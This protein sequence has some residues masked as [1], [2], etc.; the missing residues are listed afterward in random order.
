MPSVLLGLFLAF[1][2]YFSIV[3]LSFK[4]PILH[5]FNKWRKGGP[6]G[7]SNMPGAVRFTRGSSRSKPCPVYYSASQLARSTPL[8]YLPKETVHI[9]PVLFL[10]HQLILWLGA[11]LITAYQYRECK[12][13]LKHSKEKTNKLL[14]SCLGARLWTSGSKSIDELKS[15]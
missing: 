5:P 8:H 2:K 14:D 10:F 11:V 1:C 13:K 12:E 9:L 4:V 6:Q 7:F 3:I 15:H